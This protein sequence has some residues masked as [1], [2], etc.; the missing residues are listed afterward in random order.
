MIKYF[1]YLL[2]VCV[3]IVDIVFGLHHTLPCLVT[4]IYKEALAFLF[5]V[6]VTFTVSTKSMFFENVDNYQQ[7]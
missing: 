1:K 6:E 3:R 4:D 5:K 2:T 7:S